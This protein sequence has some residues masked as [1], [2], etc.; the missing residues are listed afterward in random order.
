EVTPIPLAHAVHRL[1]DLGLRAAACAHIPQRDER[2]GGAIRS[3]R[4]QARDQ[5]L[6]GNRVHVSELQPRPEETKDH[7]ADARLFHNGP[8]VVWCTGSASRNIALPRTRVMRTT[9]PR[10]AEA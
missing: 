4:M 9:A 1:R 8:L 6:E 5:H 7:K 2:H 3:A 10:D